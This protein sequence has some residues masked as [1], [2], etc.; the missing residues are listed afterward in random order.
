MTEDFLWKNIQ[1]TSDENKIM[2]ERF[3][4]RSVEILCLWRLWNLKEAGKN[5]MTCRKLFE[6]GVKKLLTPLKSKAILE[7][8]ARM[9]SEMM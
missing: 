3:L 2:E 9:S 7:K 1:K 6:E 8:H 5:V 4:Q